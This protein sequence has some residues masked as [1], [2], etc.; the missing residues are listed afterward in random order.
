MDLRRLEELTLNSS[1]PPA[2]LLYDGWLLRLG[3][4]KAKRPRSVNPVYPSTLPL[5]QKFAHCERVYAAARL[6]ALFRITP[7]AQPPELDQRLEARGY[8]RFDTTSVQSAT[9]GPGARVDGAEVMNLR[10]WVEA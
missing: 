2:Q 9:I 10:A 4:G 6:P 8:G 3:A 1:A 5:E 7:V